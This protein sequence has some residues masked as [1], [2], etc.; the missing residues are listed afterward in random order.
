MSRVKLTLLVGFLLQISPVFANISDLQLLG[1]ESNQDLNVLHSKFQESYQ[2]LLTLLRSFSK[3]IV[4]VKSMELDTKQLLAL[5]QSEDA[6]L[7]TYTQRTDRPD[8]NENSEL[9]SKLDGAV[10]R[11]KDRF[12][13]ICLQG[14]ISLYASLKEI[15]QELSHHIMIEIDN[16]S[17][18]WVNE[19]VQLRI[20]ED[21]I[22]EAD[23][24]ETLRTLFLTEKKVLQSKEVVIDGSVV[25]SLLGEEFVRGLEPDDA[26][27]ISVAKLLKTGVP[28]K[29]TIQ[30]NQ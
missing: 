3:V 11:L 6:E 25:V 24:L 2:S 27:L 26:A 18:I 8:Q 9:Y 22:A 16:M 23:K 17:D 5:F 12:D 21:F 20:R 30:S 4:T 7:I 14:V 13:A 1:G 29:N 10:A 19:Q 28:L 15:S